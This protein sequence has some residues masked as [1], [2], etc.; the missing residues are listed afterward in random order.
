M[1]FII[2]ANTFFS[3]TGSYMYFWELFGKIFQNIVCFSY[4]FGVYIIYGY[5]ADHHGKLSLFKYVCRFMWVRKKI[6]EFE[7]Q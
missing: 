3:I 5:S 2:A 4:V 1:L 7:N 6:A